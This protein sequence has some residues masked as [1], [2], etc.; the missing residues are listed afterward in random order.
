MTTTIK[1]KIVTAK[2]EEID[3]GRIYG[4]LLD[5]RKLIIAV[6]SVVTLF[7]IVYALFV[8][9]VYQANA[10]IQIEQ[11]QGNAL[12][13]NISPMLPDTEPVSAPE[14]ALL[15]SRMILGKTVND[16]NLQAVISQQY[17][18]LFGRG[19]ARLTGEVP[20]KLSISQ[21]YLPRTDETPP[22]ITLTVV[23]NER[24]LVEN[25]NVQ[26]YGNVGSPITRD[27]MLLNV[28]SMHAQPGTKFTVKYISRQAAIASL[29]DNFDVED[30]GKKTG[31]LLLTLSSDDKARAA[32]ILN[33]ISENY[34]E[35]NVARQRAEDTNSLDFLHQ[36]LPQVRSDLDAAEDKM[37]LYRRQV[38]SVDLSLEAKAVLDQVVNVDSQLNEL[39]FR[40]SEISQLYT[41]DH[42]TYKTLLDKRQTL[43]QERD[44]LNKRISTMPATQ[45]QVERLSRDVD[46][47]RAIY[48][49]LLNRQ[50][51]L[52]VARSSII[53]NVHI[54]DTAVTQ[55][56]PV[57]PQR[58]NMVVTALVAGFIFSLIL[59]AGKMLLRR[60]IASAEQLEHIGVSVYANVPVSEWLNKQNQGVKR[61]GSK[62]SVVGSKFLAIEN[63]A[64]LAIE[65]L[66][67]LRTSLYFA[68]LQA[69]NNVLMISGATQNV[70]KTFIASNLAAV[71]AQSGQRV[72]FIDADMRKG[73]AHKLF[74]HRGNKGLSDIISGQVNVVD[75]DKKVP[76]VGFD[77]I[78]HGSIPPNPAELLSHKRFEALL[79]WASNNYDL[80]IVDTA[81]ILA[82]TDAAIIGRYAGTS[83]LVARFEVNTI[84][85]VQVS[86]KRFEHVGV[87]IKGCILNSVLNKASNYYVYGYSQYN[88]AYADEKKDNKTE[89]MKMPSV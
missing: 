2:S 78:S 29:L 3:L 61:F 25:G 28:D 27:G 17:F 42:P 58:T 79:T 57:L 12:L 72:L 87:E 56:S 84:K 6:T 82:V 65:A 35:Q 19:W 11:K 81:P 49:Q 60:T 34:L 66:R 26:F 50:Q 4:G 73:Y 36:Q 74:N 23:D 59:V 80:V 5:H 68:M 20:G 86:I 85:E 33:V 69:R 52:G 88:Y 8:T 89:S 53:G 9:P 39:T 63:P 21:L 16:L 54:I 24:F 38:D 62:K 7:A 14:I 31:I 75:L 64:D 51:E 77:F 83:M 32:S 13:N 44:D 18:P 45:Q 30:Q 70:G 55:P 22:R 15:Q 41:K 48:M 76:G 67:S 46:S 47:G 10:M 40:E 71:V 37:N 1:H 43:L